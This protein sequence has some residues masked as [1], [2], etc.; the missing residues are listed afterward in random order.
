MVQAADLRDGHSCDSARLDRAGV[1]AVLV[2]RKMLVHIR[3][4]SFHLKIGHGQP[5]IRKARGERLLVFK[6][7]QD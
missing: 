1:G 7:D 2:E 6:L 3:D 5:A 4:N